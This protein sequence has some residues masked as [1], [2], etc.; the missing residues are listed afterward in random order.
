MVMGYVPPVPAA[1]VP[2]RVAV[3]LLLLTS[4]T[5]PGSAPVSEIDIDAPVGKPV[6]VTEKAPAAPTAK[7]VPLPLVMAGA[8]LTAMDTVAAVDCNA[9]AQVLLGEPQL[10]GSPR[11]VTLNWK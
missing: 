1:G 5:P 10:S 9:A 3:P 6:V 11:S 7:V 8:E 2:A 4:V